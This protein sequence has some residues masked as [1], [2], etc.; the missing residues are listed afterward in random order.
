[1]PFLLFMLTMLLGGTVRSGADRALFAC[2]TPQ[3]LL[4][5]NITQWLTSCYEQLRITLGPC[6]HQNIVMT[7]Q[8]PIVQRL[9]CGSRC[10]DAGMGS[11]NA[12][13]KE[14]AVRGA[15][16]GAAEASATAKVSQ[17]IDGHIEH[18]RQQK[19]GHL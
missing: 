16:L 14:A 15:D 11:W 2:T 7:A 4:P 1:M 12:Q 5:D 17:E 9:L 3:Q 13:L 18:L 8:V 6:K 19:V 10:K